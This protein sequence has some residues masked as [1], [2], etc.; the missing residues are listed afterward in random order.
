[1]KKTLLLTFCML[2]VSMLSFAGKF[3]LIPFT[4]TNELVTLFSN[5]DLKIHYYC[6]NY[7]LATTENLTYAGTIILDDYAFENGRPYAIVHCFDDYKE[8][9]LER[10][11]N[12]AKTLYSGKDFLLMKY[13]ADGFVPAKNDGMIMVRNT[14]ASLSRSGNNY[15]VITEIDPAVQS[16][17]DKVNTDSLMRKIQ[18][19]QD[20]GTRGYFKPQAYEAQE[21]LKAQFEAMGLDVEL[22]SFSA[23]GNWLGTPDTSSA[24]VIAVQLGS[25]YPDEYIIC[26]AHYDSGPVR[27][28]PSWNWDWNNCPGADDNASGTSGIL[29]IARIL[30]QYEFERSII[31]CAF[32]CEEPG[33][34][35]SDAYALR[36]RQEDMNIVG[37][38]NLDMIGYVAPENEVRINLCY[39]AV[40]KTFA[41]YFI[42]ICDIYF[43]EIPVNKSVGKGADDWSFVINGYKAVDPSE[44]VFC[45]SAHSYDCNEDVIGVSVN[46]PVQVSGFTKASLASLATIAK[47]DVVMPPQPLEAYPPTNCVAQFESGRKIKIYWDE[48]TENTPEKYSIY[49]EG[50]KISSKAKSPYT[51]VLYSNDFDLHC[52]KVTAD[53]WG[54]ESEPTNESCASVPNSIEELDSKIVIYPNPANSK[55]K[56]TNYESCLGDIEIF[57]IY[58]R[59]VIPHTPSRTPQT[60][61]DISHLSTGLYFVKI[62]GET[63]GKFVKN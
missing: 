28:C 6:D 41:D 54:I 35:G 19:L 49:R 63:I 60:V 40:A 47:Y 2:W 15:P 57:D 42:N 22:Q 16:L 8:D 5:K 9:Y 62:S 34:Y 52:Y 55:L 45:Q 10:N 1:M 56:I 4:E 14:E 31:Y 27:L 24:N 20:Y 12:T 43:P 18:H 25:K 50:V 48:P 30:S 37:Y 39:S 36:C 7:V 33:L 17:I 53:Y 61:I 59:K 44:F 58:G 26:G 21:W 11:S 46:S 32:S 51:D 23:A 3:V 29:E 38:V 13:L